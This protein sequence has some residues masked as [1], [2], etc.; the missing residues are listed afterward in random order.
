MCPG[1]SFPFH[2][3]CAN[4]GFLRE[5]H[6]LGNCKYRVF[7]EWLVT[8]GMSQ[9]KEE[10]TLGR[11]KSYIWERV[12]D[13]FSKTSTGWGLWKYWCFDPQKADFSDGRRSPKMERISGDE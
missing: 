6:S 2:N 3:S 12:K 7:G 4:R 10:M 5:E 11:T 13:F 8:M 1:V 9:R